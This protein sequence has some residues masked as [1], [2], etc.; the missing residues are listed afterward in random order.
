MALQKAENLAVQMA[1]RKAEN[2]VEWMALQKA[3]HLALSMAGR[4]AES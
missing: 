2:L 3:G 1:G 4:K